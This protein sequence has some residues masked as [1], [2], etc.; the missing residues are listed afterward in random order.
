VDLETIVWI[1][2]GTI[3]GFALAIVAL[4]A[5]VWWRIQ[6]SGEKQFAK[7]IAAL[8]FGDKLALGGSLFMDRRI[9][10]WARIVAIALVIYLALP[11]DLIPDFIPVIGF[12]DDLLIVIIGAGIVLRAVPRDVLE[13]HIRRYEYIEGEAR[14]VDN[15]RLPSPRSR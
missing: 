15:R 14:P 10:P 12:M 9:P 7:R 11:L 5:F 6:R 13:E 4:A 2:L 8:D 1:I 3:V